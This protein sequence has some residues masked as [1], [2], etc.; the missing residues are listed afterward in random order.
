LAKDIEQ[1]RKTEERRGRRPVDPETIQ[2]RRRITAALRKIL[3][4]GT[5][6]QL[7]SAMREYG[8]SPDSS[9]WTE[10]LRIWREERE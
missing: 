9:E 6:D 2:E 8:I 5:A 3:E 4:Y 7:K 1:V 10:C